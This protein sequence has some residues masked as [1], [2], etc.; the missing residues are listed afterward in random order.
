MKSVLLLH[1]WGGKKETHWLSWLETLLI[2]NAYEVL[3]PKIPNNYNP[4]L[5]KWMVQIEKY[6]TEFQPDTVVAHSLGA[7]AWWH[8]QERSNYHLE[9]LISVAPP[10]F[11]SFPSKM[12]SFFP[13][14]Q[15][16]FNETQH[17]I[18]Y[19]KDDKNIIANDINK[20]IADT[21]ITVIKRANGEHLDHYS[22][23][24]ELNELL[25]IL[26]LQATP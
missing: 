19:A 21:N 6:V 15:I 11:A 4:N 16:H 1:G 23:T 12:E 8:Y 24:Y 20:L 26:N 5:D 17:T 18:I 7:L 9:T 25:T 3:F 10:T 13:L 22:N 14:P 2:Q